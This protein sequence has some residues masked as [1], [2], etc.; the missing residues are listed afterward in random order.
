MS[1]CLSEI[2]VYLCTM[3]QLEKS[4]ISLNITKLDIPFETIISALTLAKV[5]RAKMWHDST[6]VAKQL[7]KIGN[8]FCSILVEKGLTT[9]QKLLDT[10]P[11]DIEFSL[12]RHPPFGS[13]L[14]E[15]V[16]I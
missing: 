15:E 16:I 14:I 7:S 11:R 5:F 12:K 6:H 9:F 8:V 4:T 1:K 3:H 13:V 2:C 10:N